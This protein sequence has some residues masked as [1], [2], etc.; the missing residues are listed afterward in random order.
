MAGSQALLAHRDS[1]G[2]T[3]VKTYNISAYNSVVESRLSFDVL[4]KKAEY[5]NGTIKIFARLALPENMTTLN[6]VWQ[7][8]PSVKNGI[9][10]VHE[11]KKNNLDSKGTLKLVGGS[12]ND[13]SSSGG[14]AASTPSPSV[15]P[16][17]SAGSGGGGQSSSD[18]L[19][20]R[21]IFGL[22]VLLGSTLALI[23]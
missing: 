17:P 7:V 13:S 9:P 3:V 18:K 22:S 23:F 11:F 19:L 8:G 2:S 6:Q 4:E 16:R 1:N 5:S 10:D 14:A 20:N 15:S 12:G 21:G